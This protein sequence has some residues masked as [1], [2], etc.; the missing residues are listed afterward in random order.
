MN[1]LALISIDAW[2]LYIIMGFLLLGNIAF[3]ILFVKSVIRNNKLEDR[4]QNDLREKI[5]FIPQKGLLFSGTIESNLKYGGNHITD[6][7]M[8]K[9]SEI[10][11]ATI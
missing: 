11:Q 3:I 8:M 1:I 10:A 7:D 5:G 9:A 2:V 4:I 6:A